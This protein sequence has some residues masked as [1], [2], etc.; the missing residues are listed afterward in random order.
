MPP[1][2]LMIEKDDTVEELC[3]FVECVNPRD[4][5]ICY[6]VGLTCTAIGKYDKVYQVV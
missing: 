1:A 6:N 2:L 3:D 5:E 4:S